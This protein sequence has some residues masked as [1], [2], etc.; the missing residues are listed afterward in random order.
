MDGSNVTIGLAA[1]AG[2]ASFLS[3]CVLALVPAYI[4]YLGGR[5]V[6]STGEAFESRWTTFAHGLAF[7]L[8]FSLVF[9]TL[10]VAAS[11]LGSA[12]YDARSWL[13]RIGGAVV[14]VFG[15]H[16]L[17]VIHLRFLDMDTR[18]QMSVGPNLGYLSSAV[19]GVFFS[20]GWSPCV[21]PILGIILTLSL[22]T[23]N[24][25]AGVKLLTAY[26]AGLAVPFLLAA[27]G[28][29]WVKELL[30]RHRKA[31]RGFN[32]AFGVIMIIVGILLF[33]GRLS[34]LSN[35]GFFVDFGL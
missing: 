34:L 16:Y 6:T 8:G 13:A 7:V 27:L 11:A 20:A 30:R 9:I 22:N 25:G 28:L 12:L 14:I 32:M 33:S 10:G 21:G 29:G 1:L 2:L 35:L 18:R 19:M 23:A 5:A 3:P 24:L 15:L 26:S 31:V 17:G 4:G